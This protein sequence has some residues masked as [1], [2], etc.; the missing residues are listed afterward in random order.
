MDQES[1]HLY[2]KAKRIVERQLG[3]F[4]HLSLYLVVNTLLLILNLFASPDFHWAVYPLISWGLA[5]YFHFLFSM[6]FHEE[7]LASLKEKLRSKRKAEALI[8]FA[9]H[10]A[11]Y[12]GVC[13]FLVTLDW[14]I[15]DGTDWSV[16]AVVGW[17]IGLAAH[18][19][20]VVIFSSATL[21]QM[22][23]RIRST[24]LVETK[25]FFKVH[26]I[27]F[28]AVNITVFILNSVLHPQE[29]Y[30]LWVFFGWGI[31]LTCHGFWLIINKGH[32][33]KKWRN[34]KTLELMK[35]L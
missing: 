23:A 14:V 18:G 1:H 26:L 12:V 24:D 5:I 20:C 19:I 15:G 16:W 33:I 27:I 13:T 34:K 17:G 31:G 11:S 35:K 29:N 8:Q 9:L 10:L 7:R 28:I 32:R 6:V 4:I 3:F 25:F 22:A 2:L 30:S 21:S